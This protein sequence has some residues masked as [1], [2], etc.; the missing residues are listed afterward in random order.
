MA[1]P[2]CFWSSSKYFLFIQ[3]ENN[4]YLSTTELKLKLDYSVREN[5]IVP[6]KNDQAYQNNAISLFTCNIF[7]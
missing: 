6:W 7:I 2:I 1:F 4:K 5:I 3:S